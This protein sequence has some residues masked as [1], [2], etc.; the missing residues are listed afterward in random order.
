MCQRAVGRRVFDET[1]HLLEGRITVGT[2]SAVGAPLVSQVLLQGLATEILLRPP[3]RPRP[4]PATSAP[5]R[6]R[7]RWRPSSSQCSGVMTILHDKGPTGQAGRPTGA[8][9]VRYPMFGV[10][11]PRPAAPV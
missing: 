2:R 10:K 11:P 8:F 5:G 9:A 4:A 1:D 6:R 7:A 3:E